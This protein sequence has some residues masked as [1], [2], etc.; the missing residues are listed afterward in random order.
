M[1]EKEIPP[2]LEKNKHYII[3]TPTDNNSFTMASYD[4]TGNNYINAEDFTAASLVHEGLTRLV[5]TNTEY[6]YTCGKKAVDE[7]KSRENKENVIKVDFGKKN[8]EKYPF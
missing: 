2:L 5:D 8:D 3:I 4:T 7:R 6:V 1:T